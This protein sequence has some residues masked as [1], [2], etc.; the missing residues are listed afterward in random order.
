[1]VPEFHKKSAKDTCLGQEKVLCIIV[2]NPGEIDEK[3]ENE[4]KELKRE[5]DV[6]KS[7]FSF[8]VTWINSL[9][10]KDWV[11]KLG[12]EDKNKLTVRVLRTGRRSKYI[13]MT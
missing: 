8:K 6:N 7:N 11:E 5:L 9:K 10:H 13:E 2:F 3:L 4:L 1:M 12:V